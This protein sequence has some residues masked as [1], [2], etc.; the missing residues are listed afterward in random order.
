MAQQPKPGLSTNVK[1]L[2][3]GEEIQI[4]IKVIADNSKRLKHKRA[5]GGYTSL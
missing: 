4:D 2:F 1:D 3:P 5:I